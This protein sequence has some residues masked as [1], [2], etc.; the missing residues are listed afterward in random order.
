QKKFEMAIVSDKTITDLSKGREPMITDFIGHQVR[1]KDGKKII[2]YGLSSY[3]YDV[4]L[5]RNFKIFSNV[6]RAVIDALDTS[7]GFL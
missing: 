7:V 4:R 5:A 1:E 2:S 3:G 6:T